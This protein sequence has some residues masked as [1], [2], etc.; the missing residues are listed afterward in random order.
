MKHAFIYSLKIWLTSVFLGPVLY[1]VVEGLVDFK[2]F[3]G[4]KGQV[5][6]IGYSI[7]YGLILS[8]PSWFF[9]L[10]TLVIF[11]Y[12]NAKNLTK[13]IFLSIVGVSL[14]YAPFYLLFF[15]D[16]DFKWSDNFIWAGS[17]CLI[18]VSGIWLYNSKP[19]ITK[20]I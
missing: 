7:P 15:N 2:K 1:V 11:E 19:L 9:L 16:D 4:V 10:C 8:M 5:G 6:F 18:I 3:D 17:Y 13:L 20:S 12:T 14:S